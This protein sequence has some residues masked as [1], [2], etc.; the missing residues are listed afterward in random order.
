MQDKEKDFFAQIQGK[1]SFVKFKSDYM[2]FDKIHLSFVQHGGDDHKQKAHIEASMKVHDAD[3]A[4]AFAHF[5]ISGTYIK[6]AAES[7]AKAE[8]EGKTYPEKIFE[9]VGGTSAKNKECK[10]RSVTLSPGKMTE[11]VLQACESDGERTATGGIK[12]KSGATVTRINVGVDARSLISIAESILIEWQAYRMAGMLGKA[13]VP[14]WA[15]NGDE[16]TPPASDDTR[17]ESPVTNN[18][19]S[20]VCVLY[21]AQNLVF[22]VTSI[23]NA[24]TAVQESLK[25]MLSA[26]E[27]YVSDKEDYARVSKAIA[28]NSL[29]ILT[30]RF[31]GKKD[32]SKTNQLVIRVESLS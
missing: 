3:G 30:I 19:P 14:A 20:T 10:F 16:S 31:K 6:R 21:D 24:L 32:E 17:N 7:R 2:Q 11:F 4:L 26:P 25:E 23:S 8:K 5:I 13:P 15:A 27:A 28:D 12:M 22:R 29:S 1:E 18:A 9:C